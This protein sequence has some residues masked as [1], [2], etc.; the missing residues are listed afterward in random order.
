MS[1]YLII[2]I[3]LAALYLVLGLVCRRK[4]RD[5]EQE[6]ADRLRY[7]VDEIIHSSRSGGTD[8]GR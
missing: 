3:F 5:S 4:V 8:P 7:R 1:L 2:I 6:A